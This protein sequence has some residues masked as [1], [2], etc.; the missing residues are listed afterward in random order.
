VLKKKKGK[1][2]RNINDVLKRKREKRK[3]EE[4]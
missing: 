4:D 2:K 1:L 3:N